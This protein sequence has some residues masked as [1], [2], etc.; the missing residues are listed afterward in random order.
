MIFR[1][2][3]LEQPVAI[4]RELLSDILSTLYILFAALT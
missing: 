4:A 2:A 1:N 3:D